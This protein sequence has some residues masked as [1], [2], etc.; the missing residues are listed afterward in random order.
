MSG[1]MSG[2]SINRYTEMSEVQHSFSLWL[3]GSSP[4]EQAAAGFNLNWSGEGC[5]GP[6]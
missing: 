3:S 1:K 2:G 5:A 4:T 6:N